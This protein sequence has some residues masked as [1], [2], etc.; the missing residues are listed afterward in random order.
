MFSPVLEEPGPAVVMMMMSQRG[1]FER[2]SA[3]EHGF[4]GDFTISS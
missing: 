3:Q 4:Q 2:L 1:R